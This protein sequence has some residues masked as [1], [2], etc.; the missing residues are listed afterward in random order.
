KP[1][2]AASHV[3]VADEI[4]V[5]RGE[6]SRAEAQTPGIGQLNDSIPTGVVL[7]DQ[8][9][10]RLDHSQRAAPLAE[11]FY[12]KNIRAPNR[13][14][15]CMKGVVPVN[16]LRQINTEAIDVGLFDESRGAA[17]EEMPYN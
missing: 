8:H 11:H 2:F 9:G 1:R 15:V 10:G 14:A 4:V 7:G 3:R 5:I 13:T 12:A 6:P 17:D 16:G